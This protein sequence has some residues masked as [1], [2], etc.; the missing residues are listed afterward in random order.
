MA[1]NKRYIH[2]DLNRMFLG[3][4]SD[5][6]MNNIEINTELQR[7]LEL[8]A[9]LGPK[10]N[11]LIPSAAD[12]IIDLHSTNSN[13]GIVAMISGDSDVFAFRVAKHLQSTSYPELK[14]T[15][16]PGEKPRLGVSIV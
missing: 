2:T 15:C 6:V 13:V 8:N 11:S 3:D 9:K 5:K 7:A 10:A 4:L 16:Y 1:E 14:I 12:F